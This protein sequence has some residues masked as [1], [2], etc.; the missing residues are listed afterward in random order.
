MQKRRRNNAKKRLGSDESDD[1]DVPTYCVCRS[2]DGERFMIACD[3]CEEW[4]HGDCI[5]VTPK[6]AEQIKTFYCP[7]CRL[8]NPALEIE[9][10]NNRSQRPKLARQNLSPTS[11]TSTYVDQQSPYKSKAKKPFASDANGRMFPSGQSSPILSS[12]EIRKYNSQDVKDSPVVDSISDGNLVSPNIF[13]NYWPRDDPPKFDEDPL[14]IPG[15]RRSGSPRMR[16]CGQCNGCNQQEDCGKCDFCRDRRKF[17]GPNRMRQ[18]CRLRQCTCMNASRSR[19]SSN[20]SQNVGARRRKQHPVQ[21]IPLDS[22]SPRIQSYVDFDDEQFEVPM[23]F[24]PRPHPDATSHSFLG[25]RPSN[26]GMPVGSKMRRGDHR[27]PSMTSDLNAFSSRHFSRFAFDDNLGASN[28]THV[29]TEL[30]NVFPMGSG[31]PTSYVEEDS[32]DDI[33]LPEMAH[34]AGPACMSP[35]IPGDRYCSEA[36]KAKHNNSRNGIR[37]GSGSMRSSGMG[38]LT[39]REIVPVPYNLSYPDHMYCR[40]HRLQ[41]WHGNGSLPQFT[42]TTYRSTN[43]PFDHHFAIDQGFLQDTLR[44]PRVHSQFHCT[45]GPIHHLAQRQGNLT[46][47]HSVVVN[48]NNRLGLNGST[49]AVICETGD[50]VA[51]MDSVASAMRRGTGHNAVNVLVEELGIDLPPAPH[52]S[53]VDVH[54]SPSPGLSGVSSCYAGSSHNETGRQ[55]DLR[56]VVDANDGLPPDVDDDEEEDDDPDMEHGVSQS[57]THPVYGYYMM[58]YSNEAGNGHT[59]RSSLVDATSGL[60]ERRL[61]QSSLRSPLTVRPISHRMLVHDDGEPTN[62]ID[63]AYQA[64]RTMS[65]SNTNMRRATLNALSPSITTESCLGQQT[66]T[67]DLPV[68]SSV[69][70]TN[71]VTTPHSMQSAGYLPADEFYTINDSDDLEINWPQETVAGVN[72]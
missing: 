36:C 32:D 10:K 44:P 69:P 66:S 45:T 50:T 68:G 29:K 58:G 71:V 51:F 46:N 18:K 43:Q 56:R 41:H 67:G 5:S 2:T 48:S 22:H 38:N 6:Q 64:N 31:E 26:P 39:P 42:P 15:K 61:D 53:S 7:Q 21:G 34:C 14:S 8:K 47:S 1:K 40:H 60:N 65:M 37:S 16:P 3:Q 63:S 57:G 27:L 4:Y 12:K 25:Y 55:L 35:A 62:N 33:V 20:S 11:S 49:H 13:H 9:Y 72:G 30:S 28:N 17:G 70:N 24:S 59:A 54:M 52:Q 23:D 19:N